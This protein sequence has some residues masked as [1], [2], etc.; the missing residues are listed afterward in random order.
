M[1]IEKPGRGR[2]LVEIADKDSRK[3]RLRPARRRRLVSPFRREK[4]NIFVT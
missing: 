3:S 1:T 4:R 2:E